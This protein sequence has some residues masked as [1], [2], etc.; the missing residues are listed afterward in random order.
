MSIPYRVRQFARDYN[1]ALFATVITLLLILLV[2]FLRVQ[3]RLAL[4]D[5]LSRRTDQSQDYATLLSKDKLDSFQKNEVKENAEKNQTSQSTSFSVSPNPAP[6]PSPTP[7]PPSGGGTTSPPPTPPPLPPVF[8]A[9]IPQFKLES[10][11][12]DCGTSGSG[13]PSSS[14]CVKKYVFSAVIKTVNGPGNVGYNWVSSYSPA[15][16]SGGYPA[17]AGEFNSHLNKIVGI[18]CQESFRFT[19]QLK[20]NIPNQVQ[21][22]ALSIDHSCSGGTTGG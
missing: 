13:G 11:F 4:S 3:E 9:S 8:T 17:P 21:S 12:L 1:V 19:L 14:N 10:T 5:V 22:G 6:T 16:G 7:P 18:P 2:F 15:N 20:V